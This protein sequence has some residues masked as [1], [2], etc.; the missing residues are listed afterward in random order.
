MNSRLLIYS[1]IALVIIPIRSHG[2]ERSTWL[3]GAVDAHGV[4]HAGRDFIGRA[5]WM[6]DVS[7][8]VRPEY[9]YRE[10]GQ[11]HVGSGLFRL[12]LDLKSGSVRK[13]TIVKST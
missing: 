2:Q 1:C 9:P 8:S 3:S 7:Y 13:V 6:N 5:P 10:R 12:T 11:R 4:R